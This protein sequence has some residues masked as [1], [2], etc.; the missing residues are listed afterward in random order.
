MLSQIY[1]ISSIE[2][3]EYGE[4]LILKTVLLNIILMDWN[5]TVIL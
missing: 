2:V 3:F 5:F 1:V 4:Q